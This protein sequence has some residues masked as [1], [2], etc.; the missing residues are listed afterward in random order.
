M[1]CRPQESGLVTVFPHIY[2]LSVPRASML[3]RHKRKKPADDTDSV[4]S[5]RPRDVEPH[6]AVAALHKVTDNGRRIIRSQQRYQGPPDLEPARPIDLDD[7]LLPWAP[8]SADVLDALEEAPPL[9]TVESEK[10]STKTI[11]KTFATLV[12]PCN[13]PLCLSLIVHVDPR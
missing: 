6:N 10:Q 12:N 1:S 11:A 2:L 13:I 4:F 9:P 5:L 3:S 7:N 8:D